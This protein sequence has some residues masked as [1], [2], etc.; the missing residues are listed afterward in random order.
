[1]RHVY[2][3]FL[4]A[5][6][7]LPLSLRAQTSDP[8]RQ[9]LDLVFANLDKTQVPTGYLA[10]YATP[11]LPL[12]PFN[13]V[14]ADSNYTNLNAFRFLY[15]TLQSARLHGQDTLPSVEVL[16]ARIQAAGTRLPGTGPVPIAIEYAAYDAVRP[17]AF[18]QNLLAIQ[19]EQVFDVP[20]R[21]QSPYQR[22]A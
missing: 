8:L 17:D 10:E 22:Q 6:L 16:N 14:L 2:R 7:L 18:S 1:M 21:T 11:L 4:L 5:T 3:L 20:G 19:S 9:K 13:G 12:A 15:A